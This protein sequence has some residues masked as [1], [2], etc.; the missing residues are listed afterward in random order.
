MGALRPREV[1]AK[2]DLTVATDMLEQIRQGSTIST[3]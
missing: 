3:R 2:D 1:I